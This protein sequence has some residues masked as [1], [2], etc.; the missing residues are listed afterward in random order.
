M[1]KIARNV[2]DRAKVIRFIREKTKVSRSD[3]AVQFTLDKK[4]ASAVVDDLL[5]DSLIVPAG[6]QDSL[7]GRRQELFALNGDYGNYMGID[8]GGTHIIGVLTDLNGR[9]LDRVFFE[10]RPGLPV[11][12]IIEQ[13]KAIGRRLLGSDKANAE[14]RSVGIC[15][16]GFMDVRT[17]TS[18]IAENIPGWHDIGLKDVFEEAFQRPVFA[19]DSSRAFALAEKLIGEGRGKRDFLLVD[20]G[21]GIGMA[22][23]VNDSLYTGAGNKSGEIGHMIVK[24]NG[25]SCTCG[26]RGCLEAVASGRAIAQEAGLG[27]QA[28]KSELLNGLTHGKPE[29]VTAQDVSIAASMGDEFC[30]ALVREAGQV[31]GL[32]LANAV[33]VLNPSRVVLGGGLI[34]SNSLMEKSIAEALR[35]YSMREIFQDMDLKVS[36]LGIDG[37]ALGSAFLAMTRIFDSEQ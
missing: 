6:F 19:D 29:T 34:S 14:I 8:L 26:N 31:I 32:A 15:A 10:I 37:S 18:L 33:N 27:M 2:K 3:L 17:G 5:G 7:A 13:M 30:A 36:Q 1:A 9:L 24:P 35:A 22:V 16:P 20:L 11:D 12:I 23:V 21:Y 25:P 28:G 4:T